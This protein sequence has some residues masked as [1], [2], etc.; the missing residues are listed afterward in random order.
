M[1]ALSM[2]FR[3]ARHWAS[4]AK[5]GSTGAISSDRFELPGVCLGLRL[6]IHI[7]ITD[8]LDLCE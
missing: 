2:A 1:L 8:F 7:L 6:A 5:A 4:M 3:V